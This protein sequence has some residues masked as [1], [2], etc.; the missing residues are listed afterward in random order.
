MKSFKQYVLEYRHTNDATGAAA[1]MSPNPSNGKNTNRIINRLAVGGNPN[2]IPLD[3]TINRTEISKYQLGQT[4]TGPSL[5]NLLIKYGIDFEPSGVKVLGNSSM[6]L[7]MWID[8]KGRQFGRI[9][10]RK[11]QF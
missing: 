11:S 2:T 6:E 4:F 5:N 7:E 9:R 1:I 8:E 3:K 10:E